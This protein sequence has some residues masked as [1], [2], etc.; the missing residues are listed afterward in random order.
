MDIRDE[1]VSELKKYLVGPRKEDEILPQI[2]NHPIDYY[3]LGILFPTNAE[4]DALDTDDFDRGSDDTETRD[5][6]D[7]VP[8]QIKQ[9]AMGLRVDLADGVKVV[10]IEID[11]AKYDHTD[12]GWA[13]CPLSREKKEHDIDLTD[14]TGGIEILGHDGMPDAKLTWMFDEGGAGSGRHRVLNIFLENRRRWKVYGKGGDDF[15]SVRIEN[16]TNAIFQPCIKIHSP[17]GQAFKRYES[18]VKKSINTS[19]DQ[20][21]D[22]IFRD[23]VI[24]GEGFNCAATWERADS[25]SWV[26]TEFIPR[27]VSPSIGKM[28]KG[29]DGRPAGVDLHPLSYA[30]ADDD[31]MY[32]KQ[33]NESIR[34]VIDD[35]KRWIVAERRKLQCL[36]AEDSC[37]LAAARDNIRRCEDAHR[38]MD[39]GLKFLL[40]D[41]NREIRLAFML[42]NRSMLHQ[43]IHYEYCTSVAKGK[44]PGFQTRPRKTRQDVLV[45][46]P[47][48]VFCDECTRNCGEDVCG[49]R[50]GRPVVVSHRGWEDRGILGNCGVCHDSQTDAGR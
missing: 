30:G 31:R 5:T 22:L 23:T 48:C 6:R 3:T 33:I 49:T 1:L 11:Y 16:N 12:G 25:P 24:F 35:Y 45:S 2:P 42:A 32:Q 26:S 34:P 39:D 21:L 40:E 46:V 36:E 15:K 27:Y 9:S 19:D 10:N 38:R 37:H 43:R 18:N 50:H 7:L 44:T 17:L 29:S 20:S 28:S 14:G 41:D 13:R 8:P 47:D 4:H